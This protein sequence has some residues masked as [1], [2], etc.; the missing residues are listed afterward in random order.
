MAYRP[1]ILVV[2]DEENMRESLKDILEEDNYDVELAENGVAALEKINSQEISVVI[3]DTRMP[4]MDGFELLRKAKHDKPDLPVIMITA[5]AT[6]KLAVEAMKQGAEDYVSKPFDPDEILI[7]I[8]KILKHDNLVKENIRL[9]DTIKRGFDISNIIGESDEINEVLDMIG[10]VAPA[11]SYVLIQGESGTGKELVAKAI[12]TQS[13]RRDDPFV[14]VNCAAI[15][16]TLLESE[17][18]GFRKGAFTDAHKDKKG[19][20]EEADGGTLFLDEIGDM[21]MPLQAKILRVLQ[22]RTFRKIGDEKQTEADVRVIAATNKNLIEAIKDGSFREDLYFRI[23]VINI[24]LPPL[25]GRKSDIPLLIRHFIQRYNLSMGKQVNRVTEDAV[26]FMK[27]YAWPGNIREL[28]N[29]VERLIILCP[30]DYIDLDQVKKN[31]LVLGDSPKGIDGFIEKYPDFKEAVDAFQ[32]LVIEKA[33]ENASGHT[34]KA[35]ELLSI[36]RHALRY[37]MNK[38]GI[39]GSDES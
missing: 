14:T 10:K 13:P 23:N 9:K 29:L 17:L 26:D 35:A 3:T 31:L 32:R 1:T 37:Q 5:Y 39:A 25:R 24:S 7:T 22:E 38:L 21:A 19:R 16:E 4:E 18:F 15:P 27:G 6:P 34:Q 12:H 33:L 11:P 2:D 20:F 30:E 36:S 28:E 8:K